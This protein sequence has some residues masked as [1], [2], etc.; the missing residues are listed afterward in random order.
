MERKRA[1]RRRGMSLIEML[2]VIA[3]MGMLMGAVA[4]YAVEQWHRANRT[5]AAMDVRTTLQALD[6]YRLQRGRYP[7]EGEGL[8]PLVEAKVLPRLPKDPWGTPLAYS[9]AGGTPVIVSYGADGAPGGD[10]ADAD[11]SSLTLDAE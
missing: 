4:F 9:L 5:T 2:V 1:R 10:G 6:I 3:I 8:R 11:I 7:Q